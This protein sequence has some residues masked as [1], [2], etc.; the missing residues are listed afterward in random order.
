MTKSLLA[1]QPVESFVVRFILLIQI[2]YCDLVSLFLLKPRP[3]IEMASFM[4]PCIVFARFGIKYHV[5][6]P[7]DRTLGQP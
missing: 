2:I 7:L 4:P 3:I 5:T 6:P 1:L